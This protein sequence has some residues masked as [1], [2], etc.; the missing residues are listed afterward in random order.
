MER[1]RTYMQLGW[2]G[3]AWS[4]RDAILDILVLNLEIK[5]WKDA[6]KR[7]CLKQCLFVVPVIW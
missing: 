1:L 3:S 2:P 4:A 5:S 7:G 6:G